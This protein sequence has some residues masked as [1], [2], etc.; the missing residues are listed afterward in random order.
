MEQ[1]FRENSITKVGQLASMDCGQVRLPPPSLILTLTLLQIRQLRGLKPPK[2]VT[3][4]NALRGLQAR[5]RKGSP[6]Q[7]ASN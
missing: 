7:V 3:V 6:L 1:D 4:R 5:L 2:E